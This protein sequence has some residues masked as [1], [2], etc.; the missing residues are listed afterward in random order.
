MLENMSVIWFRDLSNCFIRRS[1][2]SLSRNLFQH[3]VRQRN[4]VLYLPIVDVPD[5]KQ[6]VRTA[7]NKEQPIIV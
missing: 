1:G 4:W 3:V 2:V 5:S 6:A 7:C